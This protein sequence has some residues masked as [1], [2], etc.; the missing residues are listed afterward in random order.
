MDTEKV[1]SV[2]ME[3]NSIDDLIRDERDQTEIVE[4]D[5][6]RQHDSDQP[7]GSKLKYSI[8]D[9]PPW[10]AC[11]LF[12]LQQHLT[13]F[14]SALVFPFIMAN[15]YCV[16]DDEKS[17]VI[18][19][20]FSSIVL[21]ESVGTFLQSTFG[22]RLPII[23][24]IANALYV[25]ASV[26]MST[27][28]WKC[29]DPE[30]EPG[31]NNTMNSTLEYEIS[32]GERIREIQGATLVAACFQMLLGLS[33]VMGFVI[34]YVGPLTV[35]PT[36]TLIGLSIYPVS[37]VNIKNHWGIAFLSM[38]LTTIF[39]QYLHKVKVPYPW[40]TPKT[41][42][43]CFVDGAKIFALFPVL[44][45]VLISW[46][47]CHILTITDVF[48]DDP[49][50]PAFQARTDRNAESIASI[51]WIWF[52][53]PFRWGLP[54]V[55]VAAVIGLCAGSVA[56]IIESMG[57]YYACA[58]MSGAPSPPGHAINRGISM[59]GFAC[60]L[61]GMW[62]S[63][64]VTSYSGNVGAIAITKVGSRRVIQWTSALL[65]VFAVVGKIGAVVASLPTP[66][67]GGVMWV[68]SGI[69]LAIG[70]SNL[71]HTDMT[72]TRNLFIFGVAVVSGIM[73]PDYLNSEPG[74]IQTGSFEADQVLEIIMKTGMLIAGFV[75]FVLDN[76]VPG[77]AKER[78]L[79]TWQRTD[80]VQDAGRKLEAESYDL[81]FGMSRVRGWKWTRYIP[82]CPTFGKKE[83]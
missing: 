26:I 83:E 45:S 34:R 16:P 7:G 77:T 58:A 46:F 82:V 8:D 75:G 78:G 11:L 69:T 41:Q 74:I 52:P 4:G 72:S 35:A 80:D 55:S 14:S 65:F 71:R 3:F 19:Q 15:M 48:P 22:T 10:Y 23:Q 30:T 67:I 5:S 40:C 81:P 73:I 17:T 29:P 53:R 24:G 9:I 44:L 28:P 13:M 18:A 36:I 38:A 64:G 63:L 47:V 37:L 43:K 68:L 39:S 59:E 51:P 54:T 31:L 62:G 27:Q 1:Q 25:P 2:Q 61:A 66:I 33:G 79:L 6:P 42:R 76:T 49:K 50:D 60:L 20:L 32:Y 21:I 70:V 57:D 56:S 12:G